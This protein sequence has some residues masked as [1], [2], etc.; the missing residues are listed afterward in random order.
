V[1]II[2]N[3]DTTKTPPISRPSKSSHVELCAI[4]ILLDNTRLRL[5]V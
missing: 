1:C 2:T 4:H 3:N 5:F